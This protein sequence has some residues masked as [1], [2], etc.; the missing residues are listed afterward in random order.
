MLVNCLS[1]GERVYVGRNVRIGG[2]FKC[3]YCKAQFEV[4]NLEPFTIDWVFLNPWKC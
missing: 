3:N 2:I 1:C 4:I